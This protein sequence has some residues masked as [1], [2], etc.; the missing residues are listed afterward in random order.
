MKELLLNEAKRIGDQLLQ[1]AKTE[2][3]GMYWE[4]MTMD[5][6][7]NVSYKTSE[8]IYSGAA[9]VV[10]FL[11]ELYK[12]S[13][14]QRYM[15]AAVRGMNWVV[16]YCENN[17]SQYYA[18]FTGRMGIPYVL[19]RMHEFT[20]EGRYV[21]QA[22]AAARACVDLL[23]SHQ[24]V[25]DLINGT[26]GALLGL[27]HLHAAVGEEWIL[28][29]IDA[30]IKHL[31]G[32]AHHGPR[33]LYWDRSEAAISGL[34]GLSHGAAGLGFVFL[35]LGHYFQNETF[36]KVAEQAFLYERHFFMESRSNW[37][38]LRKGIYTDEDREN[39]KKAFL[40]D[41]LDFFTVGGDM[42]AWCHGAAGIGLSRLRAFQL[43]N[44]KIYEDEARVTIE[45]TTLTNVETDTPQP[46]FTLCHGGGG[47]AELFIY[48][49][50][51]FNDRR[52]LELAEKVAVKAIDFYEKNKYFYS[53]FH[54]GGDMQDMSL[55][56]GNAGIGYFYL[57]LL[58]PSQVPSIE[59]PIV[60][61]PFKPGEPLSKSR[62]P[63]ITISTADVQ[64]ELLKKNFQRTLYCAENLIP[65]KL[66]AFFNDSAYSID[67]PSTLT[68][69]FITFMTDAAAAPSLAPGSKEILSDIFDL[70]LEK[71]RMDEA[72]KSHSLLNIKDILLNEQGEEII[73]KAEEDNTFLE[74]VLQLEPNVKL[75]A[76]RWNWNLAGEEEWKKNINRPV[77]PKK[78]EDEEEEEMWA[79]LLKPM[80]MWILETEL[81]PFTYTILVELCE[82]NR[83]DRVMDATIDAFEALTPDQ[84]KMLRGK[85]I[86][87]IKHLL[88]S[89]ILVEAKP[90][91]KK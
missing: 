5:L 42:N 70:E 24:R 53:G 54:Y 17:P 80:P 31:V 26:S 59:A 50:Q 27:L 51:V 8:S 63:F 39:H 83:V 61:K 13:Q 11:L 45:K 44:K 15:D 21:E 58:N 81:S 67:A 60:D 57:R 35:E 33:G 46:T 75:W 77:E 14:D 20:G 56:M 87:Q 43:L 12:Q 6:D 37:P 55:F 19:L 1:E 10:L 48:A 72:I 2:N 62:Y 89:G 32:S 71:R 3:N 79:V 68:A 66:G 64:E 23:N 76:T 73:K 34:C 74:L 18:F 91:D 78:E 88:L 30:F 36:Y 28:T 41:N 47:N 69:S 16:N 4:T 9:G 86:D 22:L 85:I 82:P 52:Y 40:E 7:R 29:T 90:G 38:D 49:Y 65:Q 84:E 25:D